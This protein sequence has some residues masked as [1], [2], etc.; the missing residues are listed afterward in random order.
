MAYEIT[1]ACT[2]CGKC[3]R[4][5]SMDAISRGWK[6]YEIDPDLCDSYGACEYVCP[7]GAVLALDC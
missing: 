5:C 4:A 6:R 7:A 1:G 3:E 2:V